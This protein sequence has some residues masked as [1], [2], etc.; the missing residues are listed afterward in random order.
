M[1]SSLPGS[2]FLTIPS[3]IV[4][5]IF[6]VMFGMIASVG[7]SNLQFVD[8]NST[9]NLFVLGFSIFFSLVLPQW[10]KKQREMKTELGL[11]LEL[12]SV[13]ELDQ[14]IIVLLETS[15]FVGGFLGFFLDNTIPGTLEERGIVAW[16]NQYLTDK[17]TDGETSSTYDLPF[18]MPCLRRINWTR[19]LPFLPVFDDKLFK[20]RK[21]K[22]TTV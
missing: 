22:T 15:M 5:G 16:N 20:L 11:E 10:I 4:G 21:T 17:K 13:R 14:I 2:L 1:Y 3:P 6:C 8:L 12:T 7:L 19:Y 9:R 18:C